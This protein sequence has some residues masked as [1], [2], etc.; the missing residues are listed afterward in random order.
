MATSELKGASE[1][2]Q[3]SASGLHMVSNMKRVAVAILAMV[4]VSGCGVGADEYYDGQNLVSSSGQA[5][6]QG[7]DVGPQV[8]TPAGVQ[9]PETTAP[10]GTRDPGTV[11]LPQDPIP[12]YEGRPGPKGA[13]LIDP[14]FE[15]GMDPRV[16]GANPTIR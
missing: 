12:V 1:A 10:S 16:P 3:S 9:T 6:E 14:G 11:A 13:P 4:V 8:P 7:S 15:G 2:V 5:L